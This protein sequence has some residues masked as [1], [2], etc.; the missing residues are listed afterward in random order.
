MKEISN[1]DSGREGSHFDVIL[2]WLF[3]VWILSF[4]LLVLFVYAFVI[5]YEYEGLTLWEVIR[6]N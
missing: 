3:V 1:Q 6:N 4:F 5:G 2:N